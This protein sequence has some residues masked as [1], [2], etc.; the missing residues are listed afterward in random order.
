MFWE[1]VTGL[2]LDMWFGPRTFSREAAHYFLDYPGTYSDRW[3]ALVI[4]ILDMIAD[5][6]RI[7]SV[8]VEYTNPSQQTQ[9]EEHDTSFDRKRI[10]QLQ[11]ITKAIG[12]HWDK[13]RKD[14]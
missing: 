1:N 11:S 12:E 4:P 3:E 2:E 10:E 5:G 9:I 13:I 14:R 8:L 6:K 7:Q